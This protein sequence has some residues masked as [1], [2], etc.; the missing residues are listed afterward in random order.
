MV[1]AVNKSNEQHLFRAGYAS[2]F[3]EHCIHLR[4]LSQLTLIV[5]FNK[6]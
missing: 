1:P 4:P 2:V 6:T 3:V 5:V